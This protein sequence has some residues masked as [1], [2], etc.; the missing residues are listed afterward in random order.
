MR[1][2]VGQHTAWEEWLQ[3]MALSHQK[4]RLQ[5]SFS[6]GGLIYSGKYQLGALFSTLSVPL[7]LDPPPMLWG[8]AGKS[9]EAI[10]ATGAQDP[11]GP[12]LNLLIPN[13]IHQQVLE[14]LRFLTTSVVLVLANLPSFLGRAITS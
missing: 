13:P 6:N 4:P 7:P 14:I 9:G 1:V 8:V 5:H 10:R 12:W 2:L 3:V 11:P